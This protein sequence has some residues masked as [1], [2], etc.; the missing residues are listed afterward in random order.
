VDVVSGG[1]P[2]R[3]SGVAGH[4]PGAAGGLR[5]GPRRRG[6]GVSTVLP[7]EHGEGKIQGWHHDRL[8]AVYVRQSSRR[9]VVDHGESTR[10]Q[11]GLA[12]RAAA[13]G[14]PAC[15]VMVID[16]GLGRSAADAADRPGSRGCRGDH[17]GACGTGAG[18]GDVVAGPWGPGLASADRVVLIGRGAAGRCGRVYDLNWY[19][20][21]LLVR[22]PTL[23]R[24]QMLM[25]HRRSTFTDRQRAIATPMLACR[26]RA[27]A[28]P[29]RL[30][31]I[32][33]RMLCT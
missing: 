4:S 1:D 10:L 17:D 8:A 19:S 18:P 22:C 25:F 23:R 20:D 2:G 6:R 32:F 33:S 13:L 24:Q 30:T 3:H 31:C 26:R 5:P 16:E 29:R 15:R 9:Q 7:G 12:E 27:A 11:Y 28:S 14:W 21:R